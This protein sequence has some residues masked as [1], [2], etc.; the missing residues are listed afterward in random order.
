MDIKD[1][2]DPEYILDHVLKDLDFSTNK[3]RAY[4]IIN[5]FIEILFG[6]EDYEVYTE[7]SK[8]TNKFMLV[9]EFG[10]CYLYVD[11]LP[12]GLSYHYKNENLIVNFNNSV[13]NKKFREVLQI[14]KKEYYYF[15]NVS[16]IHNDIFKENQYFSD[17]EKLK[18][19][20]TFYLNYLNTLTLKE[21][22]DVK[23]LN[24]YIFDNIGYNYTC[25]K[26]D[27]K[28]LTNLT[29]EIMDV[30]S[31]NALSTFKS[32]N[33]VEISKFFIDLLNTST[34]VILTYSV[35]QNFIKFDSLIEKINS[36][37]TQEKEKSEIEEFNKESKEFNK[38]EI[39]QFISFEDIKNLVLE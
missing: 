32:L 17:M 36:F 29:G 6:N 7:V 24:Y 23:W 38:H 31:F 1:P 10:K 20:K 34:N 14:D 13:I 12:V 26:T 5:K 3:Y 21:D 4:N 11:I 18:F 35:V 9:K 33:I 19:E 28:Y 22:L 15:S 37:K 27:N 30:E 2:S 39:L 8:K 16:Y 25:E